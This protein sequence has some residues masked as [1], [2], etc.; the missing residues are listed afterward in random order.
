M[1]PEGRVKKKIKELLAEYGAWFFMPHQAGYS[2]RG[3][4]DFIGVY[5][6]RMFAIEAKAKGGKTTALQ[7]RE[8]EK[9]REQGCKT[10]VVEGD[11]L[12]VLAAWLEVV[13]EK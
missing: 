10:F 4:P 8:M 9:M 1:T 6:E 11:N 3:V 13:K 7:D 2:Q 5:R 12:F